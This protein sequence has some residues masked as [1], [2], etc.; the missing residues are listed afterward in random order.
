MTKKGVGNVANFQRSVR[1][2]DTQN[3]HDNDLTFAPRFCA[4]RIIAGLDA[5]ELGPCG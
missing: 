2:E 4:Y 1:Y 5:L 3:V